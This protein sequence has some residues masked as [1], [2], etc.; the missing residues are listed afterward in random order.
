M[1]G[2]VRGPSVVGDLLDPGLDCGRASP[3]CTSHSIAI[4]SAQSSWHSL[5][6]AFA[7]ASRSK[8]MQ[9]YIRIGRDGSPVLDFENLTRDQAAALQE[10]TVETY[11]E[12]RGE[13]AREVKKVR[14]K[15]ADKRAALVDLGRQRPKRIYRRARFGWPPKEP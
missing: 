14:F 8:N 3:G 10:V 5:I 12:G 6:S 13:N 11:M 2:P 4:S 9:D 1:H 15:L 7:G